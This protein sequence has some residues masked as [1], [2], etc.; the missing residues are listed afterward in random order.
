MGTLFLVAI[1]DFSKLTGGSGPLA[2]LLPG[3]VWG[4][5]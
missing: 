3:S 4:Q 1:A 5:A 2:I